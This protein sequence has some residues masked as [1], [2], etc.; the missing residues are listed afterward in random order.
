MIYWLIFINGGAM[1]T[2]EFGELTAFVAVAEEK[3][4]R[5]AAARLNLT[6]STLSHALRALEDRLGVR[7]LNRTTRTVSPTQAGLA[8][9]AE[10]VPAFSTI[11]NA[12]ESVNA[13]RE[14]PRGR[15]RINMPRIAADMVFLPQLPAFFG[16]YPDVRLELTTNDGF[17]DIVG[18]GFDAGVRIRDDIQQD[19]S[20]VRLTEDFHVAVYGSPGYFEQHA[21]P[22]TPADLPHHAC[23]GLREISGGS[24]YRWEFEKD[25]RRL[26]VP[27]SGPLTVDNIGMMTRI[28]VDG[29]GL[30][31]TAHSREHD[32]LVANG[33]LIR[34]LADWSISYPGFFLYYPGHR[35]LPAALRAVIDVFRLPSKGTDT[36]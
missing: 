27:V 6:A 32:E 17:V 24:L 21:I 15:V 3:S 33:R 34:V 30:V 31:Y 12:V 20:A 19:M 4:F 26:A 18:E 7:L 2:N 22:Q 29:I 35:Q 9:L 5:K 28:A 1:R 16:Q 10:I 11:A 8:L 14:S 36:L 23:I 13:F 25:G